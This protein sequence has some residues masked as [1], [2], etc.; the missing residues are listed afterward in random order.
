[1]KPFLMRLLLA[2]AVTLVAVVLAPPVHAQQANQDSGPTA[3]QKAD[4]AAVPSQHANEGQMPA[5]G[6]ATTEEAKSFTG[7][8]VKENGEMVLED[9]VTKVTYRLDDATKAKQYAGK[10]VK[11]TG[12]LDMDS[13]TIRV[14]S[15]ELV[16]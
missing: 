4:P 6:E 15:I 11:V 1:M 8:I 9:T 2:S 5:S 7:R 3:P 14:Q 10:R 12:K 16:P 13:N